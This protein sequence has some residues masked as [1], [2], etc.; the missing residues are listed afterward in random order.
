MVGPIYGH[1]ESSMQLR[2]SN[3]VISLFSRNNH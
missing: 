3:R 2:P 1:N